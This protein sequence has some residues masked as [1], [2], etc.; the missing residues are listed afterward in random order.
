MN[1]FKYQGDNNLTRELT[2]VKCLLGASWVSL[3]FCMCL[4]NLPLIVNRTRCRLVVPLFRDDVRDVSPLS[5]KKPLVMS[6]R[7]HEHEKQFFF[8]CILIFVSGS[9]SNRLSTHSTVSCSSGTEPDFEV[10]F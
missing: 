10:S 4:F 7:T 5:A 2:H 3:F 9:G 8:A 6:L 1:P